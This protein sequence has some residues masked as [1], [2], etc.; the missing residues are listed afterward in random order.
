MWCL[1]RF[2]NGSTDIMFIYINVY[3]YKHLYVYM[4]K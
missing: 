3:I 2:E 1:S 4:Y